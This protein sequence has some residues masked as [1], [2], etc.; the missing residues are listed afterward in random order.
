MTTLKEKYTNEV[1]AALTEEFKYTN[2]CQVPKLEKVVL[3][4]G[5][6]EAV[7]NPKIVETAAQELGLI[8]GQKAVIT[9]AKKPIANFKLRADLPIGCKV[10]LRREKMYDFLDRLINIALPR[11]RDFKGISGKAF[12]GRGNYSLGITEHIIFP[13]IDYDKTDAIKGLNVTVVTTA[14]TD[15]EGKAFLKLIGMPFKN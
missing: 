3:N 2:Q 14:K 4:M 9:R 12:D 8:A 13:E 15:E 6:G 1:V 7:R 10:T 11:V 5:L